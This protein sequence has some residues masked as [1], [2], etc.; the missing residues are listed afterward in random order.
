MFSADGR[1]L[2]FASNRPGGA[3]GSDLYRA[4]VD[5]QGAVGAVQSL[6]TAI[7]SDG[8]ERAPTLSLDGTRLLFASN[9]HGGAGGMDLFVAHWNGQAFIAPVA[10][11]DINSAADELDA[12]W[13]ADGRTLVWARGTTDG[14][15]QLLVAACKDGHFAQGQA[16][17][18]SFNGPQ[19]RTF[20]AVVDAAKPGELL[21][22]G[23]ARAPRAGQ[24][25]IYR[26]KAPAASGDAS[27][28]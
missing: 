20:G 13:L 12:A 11:V 22:T 6:G 26:M 4:P 3:G 2:L 5:A 18:L 25:D 17:P 15:S 24:L 19:E 14:P 7:N 1:W 21:V 10:L 9:G 16:L 28:R 23:S 8:N 27:C